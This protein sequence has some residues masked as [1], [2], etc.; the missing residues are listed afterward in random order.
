MEAHRLGVKGMLLEE[1]N[2]AETMKL[3]KEE[4]REEGKIL[5]MWKMVNSGLV[6]VQQAAD[7]S[8]LSEEDFLEKIKAYNTEA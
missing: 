2:E 8:G 5:T 4:G 1:Y 7:F 6:T 3:F